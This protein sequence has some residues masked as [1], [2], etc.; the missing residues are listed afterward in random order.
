MF[1]TEELQQIINQLQHSQGNGLGYFDTLQLIFKLIGLCAGPA[2]FIIGLIVILILG[3]GLISYKLTP[4]PNNMKLYNYVIRIES[5]NH[6]YCWYP[7]LFPI[8]DSEDSKKILCKRGFLRYIITCLFS[9]IILLL[10]SPFIFNEHTR[11]FFLLFLMVLS[12]ALVY[13]PFSIATSTG[14]DDSEDITDWSDI[15]RRDYVNETEIEN[16]FY[17]KVKKAFETINSE[18]VKNMNKK[19][20]ELVLNTAI[21]DRICEVVIDDRR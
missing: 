14:S 18:S 2:L 10:L 6:E 17:E 8:R 9:V 11:I 5:K 3:P 21:G 15:A 7:A 1:Q 4:V 20:I 12:V 13:I 19:D 16:Q